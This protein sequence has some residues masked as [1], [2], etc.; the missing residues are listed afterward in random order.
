MS[1]VMKF[2]IMPRD[3]FKARTIAIAKGEYKPK[4]G[5]PKVWF[6]SV[7]SMSQILSNENKELLEIILQHKPG[8]LKDLATLSGRKSSNLSRTLKTMA[9][10]GIVELIK[11]NKSLKPIVNATEFRIDISLRSHPYHEVNAFVR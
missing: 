10:Y 7:R 3:E 8:S 1:K 6:E 9:R 11:V 2:G 5:E 4:A